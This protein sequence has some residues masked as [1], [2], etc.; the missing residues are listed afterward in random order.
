MMHAP[1]LDTSGHAILHAT[2]PCTWALMVLSVSVQAAAI[3]FKQAGVTPANQAK[4]A[5]QYKAGRDQIVRFFSRSWLQICMQN[6]VK[7]DQRKKA[8]EKAEYQV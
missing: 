1:N 2:H 7:A 4:Y 8:D 6:I 5:K 3:A